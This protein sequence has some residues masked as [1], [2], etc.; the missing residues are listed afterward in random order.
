MGKW[1]GM[2][3]IVA[4]ALNKSSTKEITDQTASLYAQHLA[5][6]YGN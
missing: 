1:S 3:C 5:S 6:K 4:V 2:L